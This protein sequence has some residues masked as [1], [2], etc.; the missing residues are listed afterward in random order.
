[1]RM[2]ASEATLTL[3]ELHLARGDAPRAVT[4]AER[5][6]RIDRYRDAQ[7]RLL[8][9]ACELAGDRAAAIRARRSYEEMLFELGLAP[10]GAA[11]EGN[12]TG[13]SHRRP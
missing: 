6:L 12:G 7:W 4:V 8:I 10:D 2:Q 13:R 9:T 11:R 3:A 5:G 1:Y